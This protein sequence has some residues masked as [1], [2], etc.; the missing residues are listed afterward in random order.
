MLLELSFGSVVK[1]KMK[2]HPS[3]FAF[4]Q[5]LNSF[6]SGFAVGGWDG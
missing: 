6:L 1:G 2:Y 3:E 5:L 4:F